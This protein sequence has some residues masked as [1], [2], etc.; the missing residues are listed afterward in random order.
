MVADDAVVV[1]RI[2]VVNLVRI[3]LAVVVV[4]Q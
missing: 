3:L 1:P 2:V 4:N